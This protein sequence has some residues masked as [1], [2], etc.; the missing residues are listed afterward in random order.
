MKLTNR[1]RAWLNADVQA[2]LNKLR[3]MAVDAKDRADE[4]QTSAEDANGLAEEAKSTADDAQ[5]AAEDAKSAADKAYDLADDKADEDDITDIKDSTLK[6]DDR[7][8]ELEAKLDDVTKPTDAQLKATLRLV[9][10]A[11]ATLADEPEA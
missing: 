6:H 1:L 10:R 5:S 11:L 2:E 4:A 8:D 7:L 9:A 3:V